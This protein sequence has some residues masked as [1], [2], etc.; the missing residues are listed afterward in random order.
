MQVVTFKSIMTRTGKIARLPLGIREELNRRLQDGKVGKG[1]VVWLNSLPQARAVLAKQ[2]GGRPI[3]K[4]NLSG[5]RLG[6]Y[7]DWER[8]KRMNG[9]SRLA[10]NVGRAK[11]DLPQP[12]KAS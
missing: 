5:W 12:T 6:G 10:T 7:V 1:L 9:L 11:S 3:N 8:R 4:E 2:F